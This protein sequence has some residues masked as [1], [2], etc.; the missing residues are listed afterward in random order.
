MWAL[1][2]EAALGYTISVPDW[3]L[4]LIILVLFFGMI[5]VSIR[6]FKELL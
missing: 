5:F 4:G 1:I 2:T 6:L 3:V